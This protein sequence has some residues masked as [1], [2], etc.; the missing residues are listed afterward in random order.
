MYKLEEAT[1][2]GA[3]G[4]L[5]I[6]SEPT[7][8]YGWNVF[9]GSNTGEPFDLSG[10]PDPPSSIRGWV[11]EIL[12]RTLVFHAGGSADER[13]ASLGTRAGA[14]LSSDLPRCRAGSVALPAS[15]SRRLSRTPRVGVAP[16]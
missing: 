8:G 15:V 9:R 2:R 16:A 6:P 12:A 10:I 1:R 11:T 14:G 5:L 7:A 4:G 3:V 13:L